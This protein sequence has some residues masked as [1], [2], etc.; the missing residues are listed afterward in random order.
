[1]KLRLRVRRREQAADVPAP[2]AG[3]AA[4]LAEWAAPEPLSE[5]DSHIGINKAGLPFDKR[6]GRLVKR[7]RM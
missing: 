4:A 2:F 1:V 5:P 6:T 7:T 3:A